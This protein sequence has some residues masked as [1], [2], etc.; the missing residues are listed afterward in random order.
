VISEA[1]HLASVVA[2][3]GS[4]RRL[5]LTEVAEAHRAAV[6]LTGLVVISAGVR[7]ALAW[8]MPVP[9]IFADELTYSEL[10]KSFAATGT[11]AVRDVAGLGSGPL[12]PILISPAYGLFDRVP[13]AYLAIKA[14]NSVLMSLAAVPAYFLALRLV[15]RR[16]A[17]VAA[18]LTL[19]IPSLAYTG[20]IMT[21]N[22]FFPLF[23]TTIWATVAALERPT[24]RRQLVAI[25]L[26]A[27]GLATRPQAVALVPALLTA[28]V[29]VSVGDLSAGR[30]RLAP[31]R[32]LRSLAPFLPTFLVLGGVA[33]AVAAREALRG[34]SVFASFGNASGVWHLSYSV[35]GVA[36]WLLYYVAELDLYS[37]VLPFAAFLILASFMFTRTDR[38]LRIFAVVSVSASFWLLLT[39]SAFISGVEGYDPHSVARISDRYTFYVLPLLLIALVAWLQRRFVRPPWVIAVGAAVA[40]A[41]PLAVPY[42]TYIRNDAITDTFALLPWA[43]ERGQLLVAPSHILVRVGLTTFVLGGLF[44]LMR[45]PRLTRVVPLLVL[46]TFVAVMSGATVRTHGSSVGAAK[47]IQTDRAWIDEAIGP[48]AEA[49]VIWSGRADPHVVWEN[50]F[51]NRSVGRVYYLRQPSWAGLPEERLTVDRRNGR[52]VD[53]A[54]AP[55]RARF[56]LVDPWVVLRGR[57]VARDRKSGMRLYRLNGQIARISAL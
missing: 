20:M 7:F 8:W 18:A 27:L 12:Y 9:W 25:G 23:L 13:D 39:T 41:L 38:R 22:L 49:V 45:P 37:G 4:R 53:A 55:L 35:G 57:V 50:E 2:A 10:A 33:A 54:G 34:R 43:T 5:R 52:L 16:W 47:S 24:V 32:L 28:I 36:R 15:G 21:E 46:L 44:F 51:F 40:G 31:K 1:Q 56:V 17:L 42:G 19:A 6:W 26:L 29:L 14:F 30:A 48:K 3:E 11:F